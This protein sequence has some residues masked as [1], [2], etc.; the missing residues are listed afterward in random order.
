VNHVRTSYDRNYD[1]FRVEVTIL[2]DIDALHTA[3]H[4]VASEKGPFTGP[5]L[6]AVTKEMESVGAKILPDLD[7]LISG[8]K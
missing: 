1:T 2:L 4:R 3:S 5:I 8:L 7:N 6:E